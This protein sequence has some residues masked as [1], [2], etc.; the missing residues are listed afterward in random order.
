MRKLVLG[1]AAVLVLDLAF[2]W[3]VNWKAEVPELAHAVNP[4]IEAPVSLLDLSA[5]PASADESR[6]TIRT[7]SLPTNQEDDADRSS[8]PYPAGAAVRKSSTVNVKTQSLDG[9]QLFPDKIIYIDKYEAPESPDPSFKISPVKKEPVSNGG[10][11]RPITESRKRSFES[12]AFDVIKKP[13]NVIKK[14]FKWVG[15]MAKKVVP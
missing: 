15:S 7:D 8:N 10:P 14:P 4:K 13:F 1:I 3:V 11:S 12:R 9:K 5:D 6:N 2:I